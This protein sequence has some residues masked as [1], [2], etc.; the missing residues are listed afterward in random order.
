M[1]AIASQRVVRVGRC[2]DESGSV[3]VDVFGVGSGVGFVL[4]EGCA[5]WGV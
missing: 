4:D 1:D 2:G 5:E 3:G